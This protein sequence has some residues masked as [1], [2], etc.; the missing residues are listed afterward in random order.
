MFGNHDYGYGASGLRAQIER[1]AV[2]PLWQFDSFNYS[3][4]YSID[5]ELDI[6]FVF[7][8]TTTLAPSENKC[9]NEYGSV[10]F[11]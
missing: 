5:D 11:L 2:D 4:V 7:I 9:T 3:R 8:D 1:S 6:L 10:V